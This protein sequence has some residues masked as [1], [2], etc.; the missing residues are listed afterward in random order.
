MKTSIGGFIVLLH[1]CSL[2]SANRQV[3]GRGDPVY[4][5]PL[6]F[7]YYDYHE[8]SLRGAKKLCSA[9]GAALNAQSIAGA[10]LPGKRIITHISE[11]LVS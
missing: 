10:I 3:P 9:D 4:R 6:Y 7:G 2:V 8:D 5:F 1:L 11:S